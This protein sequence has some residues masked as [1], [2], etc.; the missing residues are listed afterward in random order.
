MK[1]R[2]LN[3]NICTNLDCLARKLLAVSWNGDSWCFDST[4]VDTL[5]PRFSVPATKK[6]W[7]AR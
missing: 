5:F 7:E 4:N 6:V 1:Q 2:E 3:S